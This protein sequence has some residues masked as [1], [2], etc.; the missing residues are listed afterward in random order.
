MKEVDNL[1]IDDIDLEDTTIHIKSTSRTN[2]RVLSIHSFQ[3]LAISKYLEEVRPELIS[4]GRKLKN[5]NKLIVGNRG[6]SITVNHLSKTI[7]HE[8]TGQT[9]KLINL[10]QIRNSVIVNWL[11][12][13]DVRKV[14]YM[15]GHKYVSSTERF[16]QN[17]LRDLQ[18]DLEMFHP[19]K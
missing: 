16:Q 2:E 12:K 5:K 15:I 17:D 19:M 13:Y 14:Q 3:I 11:K 4:N 18:G 9:K 6:Q 8:L 10:Q 1:E 7:M